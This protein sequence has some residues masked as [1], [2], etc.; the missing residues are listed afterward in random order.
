MDRFPAYESQRNRTVDGTAAGTG[1]P[2]H[3]SGIRLRDDPAL[4][5]S[6]ARCFAG[7]W[8]IGTLVNHQ[9]RSDM[10]DPRVMVVPRQTEL[11]PLVGG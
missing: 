6:A 11:M 4:V 1:P 10:V 2:V 5:R 7:P 3:R 9:I 8:V